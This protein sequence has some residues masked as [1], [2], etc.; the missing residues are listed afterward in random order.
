MHSV[1]HS[2]LGLTET[3]WEFDVTFIQGHCSALCLLNVLAT[4]SFT[5]KKLSQSLSALSHLKC[6]DVDAKARLPHI[7]SWLRRRR[8]E[9]WRRGEALAHS[10]KWKTNNRFSVCS[11]LRTF[12]GCLA[13]WPRGCVG[14]WRSSNQ[15]S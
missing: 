8:E 7:S 1:I 14:V 2:K 3:N 11:L 15:R 9:G 10:Y 12:T 4:Q 5:K 6:V 13:D